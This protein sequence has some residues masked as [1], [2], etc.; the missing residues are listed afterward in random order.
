VPP[1]AGYALTGEF[2]EL[3]DCSAVCPCWIGLSPDEDRCTGVFAWA[4]AS[5]H[6]GGVD[7]AGRRVVSVSFH[8]G[9]RDNGGQLVTVF[10]DEDASDEQFDALVEAFTGGLGGPL[11]ELR[12]LMGRLLTAERAPVEV[13][14]KGRGMTLTVGRRISGD[15][16]VLTGADGEV[17]ELRHGRL[18]NVLGPRADVGRGSALSVQVPGFG[19]IEVRGRSAMRGPFTYEDDGSG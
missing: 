10:V 13:A 6:V 12:E 16:T 8:A 9:H 1:T 14:N 2:I 5:G 15:G 18:S 11:G 7:V 17:T 19:G 3:C 4:V